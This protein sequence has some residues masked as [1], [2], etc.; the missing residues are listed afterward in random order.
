MS[1]HVEISC[2]QCGGNNRFPET[3]HVFR[4]DFCASALHI[5]G[6]QGVLTYAL[7]PK[8]APEAAR[9]QIEQVA[10]EHGLGNVGKIRPRLIYFPYWR[11][12][13]MVFNW[14]CDHVPAVSAMGTEYEKRMRTASLDLTFPATAACDTGV[15][16]LGV[17]T[18]ALTIRLFDPSLTK[19][20]AVLTPDMG[21]R[22]ALQQAR[23]EVDERI[24]RPKP[25]T[26]LFD[27][28]LVGRVLSLLYAP[29]YT[30]VVNNGAHNAGVV[31]DAL[32]GRITRIATGADGKHLAG[33]FNRAAGYRPASSAGFLPFRCPE[34]GWDLPFLPY[35]RIHV[36][37]VCRL[38]W[39]EKNGQ[40]GE[41]PYDVVTPS[42]NASPGA[43]FL[44]FW[45]IRATIR[46]GEET[47]SDAEA[48][49]KH[50]AQ[51]RYLKQPP[52]KGPLHFYIP[53][54]RVKSAE[55][56]SKAAVRLTRLQPELPLADGRKFKEIP[57]GGAFVDPS[58]AVEMLRVVCL[59]LL[60]GTRRAFQAFGKSRIQP[61][62]ARLTYFPFEEDALNLREPLSGAIVEKLA[63]PEGT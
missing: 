48:F 53:A 1:L 10:A 27:T 28:Q 57:F 24:F 60:P 30:A 54:F 45:K 5:T 63:A 26:M 34:C 9:T 14:L 62:A 12:R 33:V 11:I 13:S 56:A 37:R 36:C 55:A 15:S 61:E 52:A 25:G 8:H 32:A 39:M 20:A 2:P 16:S 47:V 29:F 43:V 35:N 51:I 22:T 44:P 46:F 42:E 49:L 4:C 41:I 3:A 38:G 21:A 59:A 6:G 58:E 50:V 18:Q 19:N 17:R 31:Y 7:A 40:F 23:S